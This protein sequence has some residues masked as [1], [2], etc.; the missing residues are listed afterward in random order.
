MISLTK[1]L[2]VPVLVIIVVIW[3][4]VEKWFD[5]N[6][7]LACYAVTAFVTLVVWR[8]ATFRL[9]PSGWRT[10]TNGNDR[11]LDKQLTAMVLTTMMASVVVSGVAL[12][13]IMLWHE[14]RDRAGLTVIAT[15][16]LLAAVCKFGI[17]NI[18]VRRVLD[19]EST[20]RPAQSTPSS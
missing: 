3:L 20:K 8:G 17:A 10:G 15:I 7:V 12:L 6:Y 19:G 14:L 4:A 1:W 11:S 13:G 2:S 9:L 5:N 18:M 16:F